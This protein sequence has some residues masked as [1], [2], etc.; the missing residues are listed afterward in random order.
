MPYC[1][2]CDMRFSVRV[3]TVMEH[4]KIGYRNWAVATHLSATRPKGISSV[5]LGGYPGIRQGSAQFLLHMLRE[6]WRTIV[7][8]DSMVGPV[9]A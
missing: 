7:G 9:E 1:A 4:P 5:C 8:P 3:G 2:E 6:A